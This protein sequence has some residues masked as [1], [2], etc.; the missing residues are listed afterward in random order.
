MHVSQVLLL[1]YS[2]LKIILKRLIF[3]MPV[4][5]LVVLL[6]VLA[7]CHFPQIFGAIYSSVKGNWS[8]MTVNY[9]KKLTKISGTCVHNRSIAL[10]LVFLE[11]SR[12]GVKWFSL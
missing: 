4:L 1:S 6:F 11:D 3:Y 9:V 12:S 10:N 8:F 5:F 7:L 2:T